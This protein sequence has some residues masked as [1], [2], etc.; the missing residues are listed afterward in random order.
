MLARGA[1]A[2]RHSAA[3]KQNQGDALHQVPYAQSDLKYPAVVIAI[4]RRG[5]SVLKEN[6]DQSVGCEQKRK[7]PDA[8]TSKA[9]IKAMAARQ[10]RPT[11]AGPHN[12]RNPLN[13][14]A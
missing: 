3:E 5:Q 14:S 2:P 8:A 11:C 4:A 1:G 10:S 7:T 12:A 6:A 9:F 13:S